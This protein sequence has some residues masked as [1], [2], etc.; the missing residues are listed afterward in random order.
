[1]KKF[2]VYL[3]LSVLLIVPIASII[4]VA[5]I[6]QPINSYREFNVDHDYSAL[7]TIEV[8]SK[9]LYEEI[10][11]SGILTNNKLNYFTVD[12]KFKDNIVNYVAVGDFIKTGDALLIKNGKDIPCNIAGKIT[13]ISDLGNRFIFTI[14]SPDVDSLAISVPVK[15]YPY[16]ENSIAKFTIGDKKYQLTFSSKACAADLVTNT[17][18]A[19]YNVEGEGLLLDAVIPVQ[20]S[21][22]NS[23]K[24][25]L[26][27]PRIC[28]YKDE[29]GKFYIEAISNNEK[30]RIY[31]ELGLMNQ[32]EVAISQDA[33]DDMRLYK[34]LQVTINKVNVFDEDESS[35]KSS[36]E[37][38][39]K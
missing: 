12:Y 35:K 25:A 15:Y 13:N 1:M 26:V 2:I 9:D 29:T 16:I 20:L 11:C 28:V 22:G 3:L 30:Q 21:T 17:F 32:T 31:V 33:G 7:Q 34:G 8:Q 37:T 36:D 6:N 18:I 24:N 19:S 27:V 10:S 14:K 39:E 5:I 4:V 23:K 38:Q